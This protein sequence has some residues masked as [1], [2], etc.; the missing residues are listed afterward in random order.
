M[1]VLLYGAMKIRRITIV[2]KLERQ[3]TKKIKLIGLFCLLNITQP[4]RHNPTGLI[5]WGLPYRPRDPT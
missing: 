3:I 5:L 4:S 2:K 1:L